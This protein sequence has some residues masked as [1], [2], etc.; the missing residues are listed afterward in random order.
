M[1]TKGKILSEENKI[2]NEI[3]E[4]LRIFNQDGKLLYKQKGSKSKIE[5]N[6]K[7]I[8]LLPHNIVSHNH[9]NGTSLSLSDICIVLTL[10]IKEA[11]VVTSH[12]ITYV[13]EVTDDTIYE[14][15]DFA[16]LEDKYNRLF[17]VLYQS[18]VLGCSKKNH[19][20]CY[21]KLYSTL[22]FNLFKNID[23]INYYE[24]GEYKE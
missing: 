17:N 4:H 8:E 12:N 24:I 3:V 19:I 16:I 5:M 21:Q 1:N 7:Q 20:K 23:G 14:Y 6:D 9:P 15:I 22:L 2:K 10:Q 13:L 18:I 11:H